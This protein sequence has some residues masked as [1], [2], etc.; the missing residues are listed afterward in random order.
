MSTIE[1]VLPC[2][3]CLQGRIW[4]VRDGE[5]RSRWLRLVRH[6]LLLTGVVAVLT[7]GAGCRSKPS[8]AV[9]VPPPGMVEGVAFSPDGSTVAA[10]R[11]DAIDRKTTRLNS[12]H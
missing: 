3:G 12:S 4:R 2:T 10:V 7:G 9:E 8:S 6:L 11:G 5:A 1:E